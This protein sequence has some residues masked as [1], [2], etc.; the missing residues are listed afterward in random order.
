MVLSLFECDS[1]VDRRCKLTQ[2][3]PE[4][5]QSKSKN[6]WDLTTSIQPSNMAP[7]QR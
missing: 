7:T 3:V 1:Q 4:H 6:S 5:H 2:F